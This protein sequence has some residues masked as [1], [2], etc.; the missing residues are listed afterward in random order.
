MFESNNNSYSGT[1]DKKNGMKLEDNDGSTYSDYFG[2]DEVFKSGNI[3]KEW[4]DDSGANNS[5]MIVINGWEGYMHVQ[6]QYQCCYKYENNYEQSAS[7][8]RKTTWNVNNLKIVKATQFVCPLLSYKTKASMEL[9]PTDIALVT[10]NGC[11][12]KKGTPKYVSVETVFPERES[13][14]IGICAKLI[15]KNF[16]PEKLI[17]WLEFNRLMGVDKVMLFSFDVSPETKFVLDSYEQEGFV[18]IREF[19]YPLKSK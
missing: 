18:F 14:S 8:I 11:K 15:Y 17:E 13:I 12:S 6:S 10:P 5:G 4:L 9:F 7:L 16:S 3:E 19:D 1:D 2:T